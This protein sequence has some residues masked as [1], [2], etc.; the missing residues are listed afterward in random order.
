MHVQSQQ[1]LVFFLS[2][3]DPSFELLLP[4]LREAGWEV[5]VGDT[6]SLEVTRRPSEFQ[7]GFLAKLTSTPPSAGERFPRGGAGGPEGSWDPRAPGNAGHT[8][9]DATIP[10][11]QTVGPRAAVRVRT[12]WT[13]LSKS[14]S[15]LPSVRAQESI[16]NVF[17]GEAGALIRGALRA[18]YL[19][20]RWQGHRAEEGGP[21]DGPAGG[22][23]TKQ[24]LTLHRQCQ[25]AQGQVNEQMSPLLAESQDPEF[26]S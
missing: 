11:S 18:P 8:L 2:H 25:G 6:P 9:S 13:G 23:G 5:R 1:C 24:G 16:S 12:P 10:S 17:P 21:G 20:H 14:I 19:E 22:Q 4:V 15:L 3:S 7:S 26:P